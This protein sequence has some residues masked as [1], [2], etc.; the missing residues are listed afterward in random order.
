MNVDHTHKHTTATATQ[1]HKSNLSRVA[2]LVIF[3]ESLPVFL[4][5]RACNEMLLLFGRMST[6][7]RRRFRPIEFTIARARAT[8][9]TR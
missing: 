1:A 5:A 4:T 9:M 2:L 6:R 3:D 8:S 7:V